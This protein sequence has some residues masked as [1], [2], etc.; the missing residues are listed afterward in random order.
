[1]GEGDFDA[2]ESVVE[3]GALRTMRANWSLFSREQKR[4]YR[5]EQEDIYWGFIYQLGIIMDEGDTVNNRVDDNGEDVIGL[6]LFLL[7]L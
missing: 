5:L 4:M 7:K 6:S 1:M 2:L 3:A